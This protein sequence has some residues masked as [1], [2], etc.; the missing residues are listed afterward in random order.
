[1]IRESSAPYAALLLRVS[2]GVLFIA[3][4]SLKIFV[5]TIPGTVEFFASLGL[6]AALAYAVIALELVGGI[7]L[8]AGWHARYFAIPLALDLAGAIVTV[9]AANG[10][11]F[12]NKDGGWEYPAF[13]LVALIVL[14]LLGDGAF[15]LKR[16]RAP[17]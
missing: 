2:L 9:H 5:F 17:A 8:I 16:T 10:W 14:F 13:W 3:H 11:L 7:A 1:M 4:A 15:A 6:P 12:T